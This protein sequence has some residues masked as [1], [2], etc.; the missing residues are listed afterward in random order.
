MQKHDG[1][2]WPAADHDNGKA[3]IRFVRLYCYLNTSEQTSHGK[4]Y[5]E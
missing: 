4:L 3:M 1:H 5:V 2:G